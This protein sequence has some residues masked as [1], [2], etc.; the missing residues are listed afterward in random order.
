MFRRTIGN[1]KVPEDQADGLCVAIGVVR[2]LNV[3]LVSRNNRVL[4]F[5]FGEIGATL[6]ER[7]TVASAS[8]PYTQR[9]E[10]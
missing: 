9:P 2:H 8:A 10:T 6:R 3:F 4:L 7:A 1:E 5:T